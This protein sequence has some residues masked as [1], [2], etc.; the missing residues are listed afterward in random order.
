MG[1]KVLV[2]TIKGI[3]A[4]ARSGEMD[5]AFAGYR[6]LF[7]GP[8]FTGYD[9]QDRRQALRIMVHAKGVPDPPSPAMIEAHRAALGPLTALASASGDP[10][11]QEM[12]GMCLVV[13]GEPERAGEVFRAALAVERERNL[14]SDLC[15][16]LMKRVSML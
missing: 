3:V 9:E 11:D 7:S 5:A 15:G 2:E 8:A 10:A 13:V 14:Q 4:A 1:D 12:L 6:A 16:A